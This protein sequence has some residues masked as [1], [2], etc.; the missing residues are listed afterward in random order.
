MRETM[1][2]NIRDIAKKGKVAD[3]K[4]E[5]FNNEYF[6]PVHKN[7]SDRKSYVVGLQDRIKALNLSR[8]VEKGNL[9]SESYAVQWLG[10]A[11]FNRDYLAEHPRVKQRGGFGYEEWNAAIQKFH[12]E[13]PKLDYAKIEHAVK[14]FR[15]IYDQLYQDMNRVRM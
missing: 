8:K 2:R 7:E 5:A 14:E 12:E 15:S 3:E 10:E 1:E 9:V 11:E 13:N 6:R 4:A